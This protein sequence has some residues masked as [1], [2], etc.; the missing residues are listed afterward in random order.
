MLQSGVRRLMRTDPIDRV[1]LGRA[2]AERVVA[3]SGYPA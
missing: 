3:A 2:V 1:A